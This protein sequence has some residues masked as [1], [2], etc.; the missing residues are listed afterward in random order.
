MTRR[1]KILTSLLLSTLVPLSTISI[2]AQNKQPMPERQMIQRER[3]PGPDDPH[4]PPPGDNFIFVA[5]EMN[6]DGKVVK[7]AP[8]SAQAVTETTQ[9][10]SDGNRI[11]NK[12][13]ATVYRDSEGRTRREQIL[14]V[15][16][17][18]AAAGEPP[19]TIFINDPV[20]G[21]NYA[22]DTR[23]KVAHKM[24]P[25]RFEFKLRSPGVGGGIGT[26]V[27]HGVR[28]S[29]EGP[30]PPSQPETSAPMVFER[31]APPPGMGVGG[32][33]PGL[34][35]Q[36]PEMVFE[37]SAIPP[38]AGEGGMVF[39][40]TGAREDNARNESLGKQSIEG[41]EAEGTRRTVEIPAGEIGNER[42]IEI[43]FER[44]YSPELQVVVMTKHSDPRFGET[45]YRLTNINRSEPAHD[46]FEVPGD[47]KVQGPPGLSGTGTKGP[48]EG[49]SGGVLNGKA[50]TLPAPEYPA[51]ARAA[52][53]SG[54]VTVEITI[55]EEGNV[56]SARSVSGHPLLQSAAVT[57]A[58][59]AKF[60]PTR[61]S[62][63]PVKV[64]GV[65]VYNF[66]TQ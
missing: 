21:V 11:I 58:R 56:I 22:L 65:L 57:A 25:M 29:S 45:T 53:A 8:Y 42:P 14:R 61:L 20:A 66:V 26:G 27:G 19:Q 3:M 64:N 2:Y 49:L 62:G 5:S 6:S 1:L 33:P 55:D 35:G 38:P 17:P 37:R 31:T 24:P 46:L 36:G 32:P 41:V 60:S 7:G 34:P 18:F 44:W 59:Q 54:N 43:V 9:T 12:S 16:G 50:I 4:T 28:I 23:S 30:P 52:K 63:Q 13:T 51:V 48:I 40:W 39:Q 47:Y 10:L 15:M